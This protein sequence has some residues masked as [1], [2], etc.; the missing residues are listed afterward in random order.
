MLGEGDR[1]QDAKEGG[2]RF[3]NGVAGH[4]DVAATIVAGGNGNDIHLHAVGIIRQLGIRCLEFFGVDGPPREAAP[5][6]WV[7]SLS[8]PSPSQSSLSTTSETSDP[9]SESSSEP[10]TG[11]LTLTWTCSDWSG[12]ESESES[13]GG[14]LA[15]LAGG[16]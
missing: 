7:I 11:F 12:S 13:L 9:K 5:A 3:N 8:V 10:E 4:I 1:E 16:G 14:L 2:G 15:K 6:T